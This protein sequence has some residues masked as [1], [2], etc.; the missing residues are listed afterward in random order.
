MVRPRV[1]WDPANSG[2]LLLSFIVATTTVEQS[3]PDFSTTEALQDVCQSVECDPLRV[4]PK[5][6]RDRRSLSQVLDTTDPPIKT[7]QFHGFSVVRLAVSP[8]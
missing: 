1:T 5:V 7:V 6:S 3:Y 8:L 4:P 2:N